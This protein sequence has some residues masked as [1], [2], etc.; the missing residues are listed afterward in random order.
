MKKIINKTE[1]LTTELLQGYCLAYKNKVK[2]VPDTHI[3]LR[4]E[5]KEKGKVKF[6]MANGSGHEPCTNGWVGYGMMDMNVV[7]DIFTAA[8]SDDILKAL[9]LIDDGSPILVYIMNHAGDVLNG[10]L[11]YEEAKEKG[12]DVHKFI[13]YD[14]IASA[15][16]GMEE[17]RRGMAGYIFPM[18][19]VGA[20]AEEGRNI[21]DC[22]KMLEDLR[23]NT[24]TLAVAIN[25]GTNPISGAELFE[26]ADDEIEIGMGAHGEGGANR[27]KM[28]DAKTLTRKMCDMLLEDGSYEKG[29]DILVFLN[30]TGATTVM[31]MNIVYKELY[32]YLE[33]KGINPVEGVIDNLLTTQECAGFS[34][35]FLK[36][37][38]EMLKYWN[39]PA[40][41][42][43]FVRR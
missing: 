11:A 2:L 28:T 13:F 4:K 31:E 15:P 32:E 27:I 6:M 34:F 42:P 40:D 16:K 14:D 9:E 18:K 1:N 17:E 24:R 12:L 21:D 36:L 43:Y 23:N 26:L 7:G 41:A 38:G 3:V 19:I 30:G 22:L 25:G 20:M 5:P 33:E 8:S 39:A 10:T 29:D 37:E 35:S